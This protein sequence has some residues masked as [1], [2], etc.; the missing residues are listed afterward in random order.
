MESWRILPHF[1]IK[2]ARGQQRTTYLVSLDAGE[3]FGRD[4]KKAKVIKNY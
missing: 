3:G 1:E 2:Q 4:D